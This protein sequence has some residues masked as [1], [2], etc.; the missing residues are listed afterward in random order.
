MVTIR[1]KWFCR[2]TSKHH[3]QIRW[4]FIW[5][6]DTVLFV[7]WFQ[8][9]PTLITVYVCTLHW[10]IVLRRFHCL[11]LI[12]YV[13]KVW[14]KGRKTIVMKEC[15]G[16]S[17]LLEDGQQEKE[18]SENLKS[19][20]E[21]KW[22]FL[23]SSHSPSVYKYGQGTPYSSWPE[24]LYFTSHDRWFHLSQTYEQIT[25]QYTAGDN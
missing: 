9:N 23:L 3:G 19:W 20:R 24:K 14:T 6:D 7:E 11:S 18:Q 17:C 16:E 13:I 5:I 15:V 8:A 10:C 21:R 2:F 22:R 1:I 12:G 4:H 25:L